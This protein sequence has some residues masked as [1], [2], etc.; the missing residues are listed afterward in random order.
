[1][2]EPRSVKGEEFGSLSRLVDVVFRQGGENVMFSQYPQLFNEDNAE[3]LLVC[4]DNGKVVSHFGMTERQ[5]C[6]AGCLLKVACIGAVATYEESRGKGLA[7][8]LFDRSREK[9]FR[10]GIDFML[11]SGGRGLYRR[12]GAADFGCDLQALVPLE[13]VD[14]MAGNGL[15]V[16]EY[17]A[18]DCEDCSMGYAG[19]YARFIRTLEDWQHFEQ[20]R[21]AMNGRT[22]LGVVR[23]QGVFVG[24]LALSEPNVEGTSQLVEFAGDEGLLVSAMKSVMEEFGAKAVNVHLQGSDVIFR[25][26]LEQA[27]VSFQEQ[28]N[29]GTLVLINFPQLME[30]LEPW[31]HQRI[32]IQSSRN[33]SF[34]QQGED[35]VF[36]YGTKEHVFEGKQQAAE[37][38]FGNS[39]IRQF[40]EPWSMVF[41]VPGLWYG[42]NY[43]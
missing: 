7:T 27:G 35:F 9:A 39:K 26:L 6:V 5:A 34:R 2:E 8:H 29:V 37:C 33:L 19:K 38:V 28:P 22:R 31:F 24:Y 14:S 12:A 32:G 30:R 16:S 25:S 4:V 20:S 40:G 42:L 13:T 15:E 21:F 1:M 41:P 10:D 23:K 11:I 3:N 36:S 17:E 18:K 43:V